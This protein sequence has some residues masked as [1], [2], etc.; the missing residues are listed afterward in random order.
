LLFGGT[1][2]AVPVFRRA[3]HFAQPASHHS[4]GTNVAGVTQAERAA[5]RLSQTDM[6]L[7]DLYMQ[8]LVSVTTRNP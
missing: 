7:G 1:H 5:A 6:S 4:L 8:R 2:R 3:I